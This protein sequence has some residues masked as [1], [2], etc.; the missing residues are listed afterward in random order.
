MKPNRLNS[1]LMEA[2]IEGER[3]KTTDPFAAQY[4]E[5]IQQR[6]DI[7]QSGAEDHKLSLIPR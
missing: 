5:T 1:I 4:N 7:H 3:R 2:N 6:K